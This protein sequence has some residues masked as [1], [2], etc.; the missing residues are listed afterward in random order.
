MW[1]PSTLILVLVY[2][3]LSIDNYQSDN[4]KESNIEKEQ[5]TVE[6][7]RLRPITIKRAIEKSKIILHFGCTNII[8][9]DCTTIEVAIY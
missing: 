1:N 4:Y 9:G 2:N 5:R 3:F 7:R 6:E 8:F